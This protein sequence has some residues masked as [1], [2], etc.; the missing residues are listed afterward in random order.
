[1]E[2]IA[3][4]DC[5]HLRTFPHTHAL[6]LHI[7][8]A[9]SFIPEQNKRLLVQNLFQQHNTVVRRRT[10]L[11]MQKQRSQK[12][13]TNVWI[14]RHGSEYARIR[15]QTREIRLEDLD[16]HMLAQVTAENRL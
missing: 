16:N 9:K 15:R 6:L 8:L 11:G 13:K 7:V 4:V 14:E 2:A 10:K 12:R 3:N 5:A 1:M